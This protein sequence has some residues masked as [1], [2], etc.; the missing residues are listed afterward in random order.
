MPTLLEK[1]VNAA[2]VR[3]VTDLI[4]TVSNERRIAWKPVGDNDNN[5][6]TINLGS[7]PGAGVIERITNAFDAVLEMEWNQRGQPS[8]LMSPRSA[9]AQFFGIRDG[10]LANVENLEDPDIVSLVERVS[11]SLRDSERPDRPTVDVRDRGVGLK[12]EEFAGTILSLNRSRKL[13]RLFL[14]GAYG[15]GGST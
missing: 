3:D 6:A 15:Q 1:I 8:H 11:V 12:A 4:Q 2:R 7:D 13:R 5:L 10:K 14:A 9:V